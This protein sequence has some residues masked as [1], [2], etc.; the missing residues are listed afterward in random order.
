MMK[1][2]PTAV[3]KLQNTNI[4]KKDNENR[5]RKNFGK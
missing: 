1:E 3:I 5:G 2:N 4:S